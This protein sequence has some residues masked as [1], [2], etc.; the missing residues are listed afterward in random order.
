MQNDLWSLL[1]CTFDDNKN[2]ILWFRSNADVMTQAPALCT[3]ILHYVQSMQKEL[4]TLTT[5]IFVG[6]VLTFE[7]ERVVFCSFVFKRYGFADFGWMPETIAGLRNDP[8][9]LFHRTYCTVW[10]VL[11]ITCWVFW[12]SEFVSCLTLRLDRVQAFDEFMI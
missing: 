5:K 4:G 10:N 11:L 2:M 3:L 6:S 9:K 8:Y 7:L 12:M 1:Q